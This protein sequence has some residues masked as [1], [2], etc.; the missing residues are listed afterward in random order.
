MRQ[1]GHFCPQCGQF[2]PVKKTLFWSSEMWI[3]A[4]L[5]NYAD[6]SRSYGISPDAIFKIKED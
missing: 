3:N 4:F 2:S 1:P 5:V 6:A